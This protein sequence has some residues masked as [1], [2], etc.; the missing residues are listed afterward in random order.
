MN[1]YYLEKAGKN[2]LSAERRLLPARFYGHRTVRE[3]RRRAL[4][5]KSIRPAPQDAQV[6]SLQTQSTC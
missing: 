3:P 4:A 2:S 6:K 1:I 5:V